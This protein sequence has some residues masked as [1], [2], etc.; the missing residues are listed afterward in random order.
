MGALNAIRRFQ[1]KTSVELSSTWNWPRALFAGRD[2]S[3][4]RWVRASLA[5]VSACALFA[6][7]AARVWI[8]CC[9]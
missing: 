3:G 5:S 8:D 7:A 4:S 1:E 2:M 6:W 9:C